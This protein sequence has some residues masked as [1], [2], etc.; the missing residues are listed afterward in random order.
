MKTVE[1]I[2]EILSGFEQ[3][4]MRLGPLPVDEVLR[5]AWQK[6]LTAGEPALTE[7][8]FPVE[9]AVALVRFIIELRE[10]KAL[11]ASLVESL[12]TNYLADKPESAYWQNEGISPERAH[13]Y[14]H[15]ACQ[16][17]LA[18]TAS[19]VSGTVALN[20][21]K[22]DHCPV[23]GAAP[24]LACYGENGQRKLV[25]GACMTSWQFKRIGCVFCGEERPDQLKKLTADELPAW[26]VSLCLSCRGYIKTI[27]LR[28]TAMPANWQ[29]ATMASLPLDYAIANWLEEQTNAKKV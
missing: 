4:A 16:T 5:E 22:K 21:W 25:C 6:R 19:A 13:A 15:L 23:C 20:G 3:V 14:I 11:A 9:V 27:D 28:Q 29:T 8:D 2:T 12:I 10:K 18:R 24:M 1:G 7:A 17:A 26:T